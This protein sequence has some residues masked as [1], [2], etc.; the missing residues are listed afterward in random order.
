MSWILCACGNDE[1]FRNIINDSVITCKVTE[2][3]KTI[4]FL[5]VKKQPVLLYFPCLSISYHTKEFNCCLYFPAKCEHVQIG[6]GRHHINGDIHIIFNWA[7]RPQSNYN[8][9]QMICQFHQNNCLASNIC[10]QFPSCLK[11]QINYICFEK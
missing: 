4:Q 9:Y 6:G 8:K 1:Y 3:I 7:L 10:L 2:P 5:T 11:L